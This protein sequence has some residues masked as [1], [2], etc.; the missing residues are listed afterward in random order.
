MNDAG[1]FR[2]NAEPPVAANVALYATPAVPP[3]RLAVV[4]LSV[5]A[6]TLLSVAEL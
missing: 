4:I 6:M 1:D 2:R 5:A 3:G